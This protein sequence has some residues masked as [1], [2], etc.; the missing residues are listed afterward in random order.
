VPDTSSVY[1]NPF[2]F[3]TIPNSVYYS[4]GVY[5]GSYYSS[6]TG[7]PTTS[8]VFKP[9]CPNGS[10]W[11]G[12][13]C[14]P[15]VQS[16]P[17]K[18]SPG[19]SYSNGNCYYQGSSTPNFPCKSG[20]WNGVTCLSQQSSSG[21]CGSGKYWNGG[22]CLNTPS[23]SF[24][25]SC[26]HGNYFNSASASCLKYPVGANRCTAGQYWN[27]QSCSPLSTTSKCRSGNSWSGTACVSSGSN[28]CNRG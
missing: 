16:Y 5:G 8:T 14:L 19:F 20:N 22:V 7:F 15:L 9:S 24:M 12:T 13:V 4:T 11:A 21:N 3:S 28:R 10:Y 23:Q 1:Y 18:C 2:T 27:G 17:S 25:P 26:S 6:N